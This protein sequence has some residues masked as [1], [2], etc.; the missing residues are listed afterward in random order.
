M[1]VG[2]ILFMRHD[3]HDD[4]YDT[5]SLE[6]WKNGAEASYSGETSWWAEPILLKFDSKLEF[7]A[8]RFALHSFDQYY[9]NIKLENTLFLHQI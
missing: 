5:N 4:N 6:S 3:D 7:F 9:L 2:M 8:A 1:M